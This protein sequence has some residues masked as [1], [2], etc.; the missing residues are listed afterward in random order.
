M[1]YTKKYQ[2]KK[3]DQDDAYDIQNENDNMDL[4]DE[5]LKNTVDN[6][7]KELNAAL[8]ELQT[9]IA[10]A[11]AILESFVVRFIEFIVSFLLT[12]KHLY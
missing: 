7:D 2:F 12:T 1:K 10:N 5:T 4:I 11:Q 8:K 3:P 6:V 9:T